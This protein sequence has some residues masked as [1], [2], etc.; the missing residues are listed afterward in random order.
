[1]KIII[2]LIA[3]WKCIITRID[4]YWKGYRE[5]IYFL[6][7]IITILGAIQ[8]VELNENNRINTRVLE[9]EKP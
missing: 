6:G 1:V 3:A 5:R 4:L 8:A 7:I 2:N 9:T